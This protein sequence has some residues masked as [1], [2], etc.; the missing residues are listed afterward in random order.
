MSGQN[1]GCQGSEESLND[2]VTVDTRHHTFVQTHRISATERE[3][4]GQL[5]TLGDEDVSK[6]GLSTVKD[7]PSGE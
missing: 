4:Q 6:Q 1:T 7:L 3:P 5:R 2:V